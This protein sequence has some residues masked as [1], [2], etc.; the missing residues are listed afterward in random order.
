MRWCSLLLCVLLGSVAHA[1]PVVYLYT[2]P[3]CV[4]CKL[5]LPDAVKWGVELRVTSNAPSWV[6]R[7]P[8]FHWQ[9]SDGTWRQH[10]P[11]HWRG[12]TWSKAESE[13]VKDL[14]LRSTQEK[15]TIEP[16]RPKASRTP[17]PMVRQ[18][19]AAFHDAGVYTH[20]DVTLCRLEKH[21]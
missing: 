15:P 2:A 20:E 13:R 18:H 11:Q 8:T 9:A 10:A 4:P 21:R 12:P 14:I 1:E 7:V 19:H 17:V 5:A 6:E 3:G 16:P